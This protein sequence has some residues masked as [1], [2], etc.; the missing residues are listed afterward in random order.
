VADRWTLTPRV[1]RQIVSNNLDFIWRWL[2]RI[3][4]PAPDVDDAVQQVFLVTASKLSAIA[5]GSER[6]FLL[7]TASRI[8]ANAG[9]LMKRRDRA[10]HFIAAA[11]E[12]DPTTRYHPTKRD[13][14]AFGIVPNPIDGERAPG[15]VEWGEVFGIECAASA[16][17]IRCDGVRP[18][19]HRSCARNP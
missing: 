11:S 9:R 10:I 17:D 13:P 19:K 7:G 6:A 14:V 18:A 5:V 3:G 8:A 16:Y 12:P 15:S 4:V 2:R 1:G